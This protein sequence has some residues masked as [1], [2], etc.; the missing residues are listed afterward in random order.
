LIKKN[1]IFRGIQGY[2][3]RKCNAQ[4]QVT[5]KKDILLR[6]RKKLWS[7]FCFDYAT[8]GTLKRRYRRSEKWVRNQ[9]K[10][11]EPVCT[12][13]VPR[14]MIAVMDATRVG[15]EWAFVVR[16]P[17]E[18]ENVYVETVSSESTYC[19]QVAVQTLRARGFTLLAVVGDGKVAVSWLFKGIPVQM[20]HF[21]QKQIVIRRIT[22]HP[23]LPAGME[24]LT[25]TN[26]LT[27]STEADFTASF[28][29]WCE[30]WEVFLKEKT[31]NEK[32]GRYAYT[33]RNLRSA[34]DSIKRHLPYLFTFE[35][36]PDLHIPNTTNSLDGSFTKI[37]NSIAVHAGLSRNQKMKMVKTLL[38]GG[39]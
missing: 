25:I 17:H 13:A 3:C 33:H 22:M 24:L 28:S 21:H 2:K 34:R 8:V 18:K 26:T 36:Y 12:P 11:H 7:D 10:A 1:G 20:C 27:T 15:D 4:F 19:Y 38:G 23:Q 32:S 6:I 29:A 5:K 9:L 30:R 39:S 37:K 16:D 14:A 35:R 31:L